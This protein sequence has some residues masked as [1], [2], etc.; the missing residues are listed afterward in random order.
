MVPVFISKPKSDLNL[1]HDLSK[2][3]DSKAPKSERGFKYNTEHHTLEDE[4][5][6]T[7]RKRKSKIFISPS[8]GAFY[9]RSRPTEGQ[10][11]ESRF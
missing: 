7:G 3:L 1:N 2:R 8:N 4:E 11:I 6:K 9:S 10:D 5:G